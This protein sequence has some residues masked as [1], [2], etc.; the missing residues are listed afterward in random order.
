[1]APRIPDVPPSFLG[2][3]SSLSAKHSYWLPSSCLSWLSFLLRWLLFLHL[4]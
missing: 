3:L 4:S 1:L 2:R